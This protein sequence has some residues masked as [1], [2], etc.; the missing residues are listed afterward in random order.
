MNILSKVSQHLVRKIIT[1][2]HNFFGCDTKLYNTVARILFKD[3]RIRLLKRR[4]FFWWVL[5]NSSVFS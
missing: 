3:H 4:I 2:S 5:M 1:E